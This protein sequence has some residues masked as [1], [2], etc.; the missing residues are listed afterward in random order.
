MSRFIPA[1]ILLSAIATYSPAQEAE[2]DE[3]LDEVI[4]Q[5]TRSGVRAADE[6]VRVD[7]IPGEEIDEKAMMAPGNIAMLINETVGVRVQVT[8]PALG[9]STPRMQ[10]LNG[11]YTQILAD[12]LPLYGGQGS[13]LSILQI[14]PVDLGQIELI[15][16]TASAMYGPAAL[17]GVINLI[18]RRPGEMAHSDWL[19]NAT[20]QNGQ[21]ATGYL[22][23]PAG[24]LGYS[25]TGGL[26]RQSTQDLDGDGWIDI[27][28]FGRGT[29]R[30]RLHW[31][32]ESG[33]TM[34][35]TMGAMSEDR[36]G[37]T[38]PGRTTPDGRPFLQRQNSDS[39]DAGLLAEIPLRETLK[40]H[41]RASGAAQDHRHQ[42]GDVIEYDEHDAVFAEAMLSWRLDRSAIVAGAAYQQDRYHSAG[43][44]AFDYRHN[45]PALFAQLEQ[46]L[47]EE[48]VLAGSLRWDDHNVYGAHLSPRVSLLHKPGEW[49]IRASVGKGF[50]APTPF[51]EDIDEVGLSRLAPLQDLQA[52]RAGTAS[53]DFG[54][55]IGPVDTSLT[56]FASRIDRAVQVQDLAAPARYAMQLVNSPQPT[57]TSGAE[58]LLRYR[59]DEITLS[60]SYV[61]VKATESD[62]ADG[63]RDVANTPAHTAGVD[64]MWERPGASRLGLE[65]YYTGEQSLRDNPYRDRGSAH[66]EIGLLGEITRGRA[67]FFLNLENLLDVRQT[68][69]DPLVLPSRAR[70]G[71]WTVD[72]WQ[73]TEGFMANAGI[74]WRLGE[75]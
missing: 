70:D 17:G 2:E 62:L 12:G 59:V 50:Y 7:V 64:F 41:F 75:R 9:A 42:Y 69:L 11:R 40:V 38:L 47:G 10:G 14:P 5:S 44:P 16:G 36:D 6:P 45:A 34:L 60:G 31:T 63:R 48:L 51:V 32:G 35:L 72:A 61:Y 13:S 43:F 26:H 23:M 33:A 46:K 39:L 8:S 24:D 3:E 20:S 21:D 65:V 27:P 67:S 55:H 56:L 4:V 1:C 73:S 74:R 66:V 68:K 58:L 19:I 71:R 49:T 53:L 57:R 25:I 52:E 15:K 22:S 54:R 29:L 37:G 30:P 28:G 18:A